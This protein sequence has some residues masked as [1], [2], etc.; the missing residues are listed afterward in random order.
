MMLHALKMRSAR[1]A[2]ASSKLRPSDI[3]IY[4]HDFYRMLLLDF[5]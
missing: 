3:F 4:V 1:I 2:L 5:Y